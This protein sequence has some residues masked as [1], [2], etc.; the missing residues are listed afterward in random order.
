MYLWSPFIIISVRVFRIYDPIKKVKLLT[1]ASFTAGAIAYV[2]KHG[3]VALS[4]LLYPR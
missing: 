4:C 3:F 2:V 1:G